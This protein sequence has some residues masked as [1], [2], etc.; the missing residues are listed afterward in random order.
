MTA[1]TLLDVDGLDGQ[2]VTSVVVVVVLLVVMWD[3]RMT[4]ESGSKPNCKV[5]EMTQHGRGGMAD[6]DSDNSDGVGRCGDSAEW[7]E[8]VLGDGG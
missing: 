7:Q 2:Q 6:G 1:K 5:V 3:R 8:E 4:G